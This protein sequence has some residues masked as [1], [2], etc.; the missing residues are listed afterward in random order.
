MQKAVLAAGGDLSRCA[1]VLSPEAMVKLK[2]ASAVAS[3]SALINNNSLDG[4]T[5]YYTP[6]LAD[7]DTGGAGLGSI[8][9]GDFGLGMVMAFFGGIDLLV[10]PYSNAGTAQIALHVNKFYDVDVRQ[11]TLSHTRR[12]SLHKPN[13]D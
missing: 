7:A 9:F 10:D 2:S 13:N 6:Q 3:V 4:Y 12:T 8:A 1:Y 11:L 5:T